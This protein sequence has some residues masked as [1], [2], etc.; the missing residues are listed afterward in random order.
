M[1]P[2]FLIVRLGS[3]GDLIHTLPAVAALRRAHPDARID[4]LVEAPHRQLLTLVP[5]LSNIVVLRDR[6]ASA[7]MQARRELRARRYDVALDFQGLIKSAALA[8][9]SGARSVIGFD[10][11][12][13]RE[14]AARFFYTRTAQVGEGRHVIAKN[15][16]LVSAVLERVE[17]AMDFPMRDIESSALDALRAQGIEKFALVN[18]GAA[19]PNKRWPAERFGEIARALSDTHGLTPVVLWGPGERALAESVVTAS[20]G[21]GVIAPETQLPDLV[22]LSRAASFMISGDTGPLHIA[23]ATGTPTVSLFGPTDAKRN[24]PWDARDVVLS[25][26]DTCPCHYK[27]Q[28]QQPASW[29]LPEITVAQVLD[30]VRT[31]LS[32]H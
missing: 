18:P 30:A 29:C 21:A 16:A 5:I 3:L 4:W 19:W 2:S 13:L 22:A 10:R 25:R 6:S 12:A 14:P 28:C 17:T 11:A 23:C 32:G 7:W 1:T 31:R 27:R 26:Y 15:L 8:R 20:G 9:L 24:G